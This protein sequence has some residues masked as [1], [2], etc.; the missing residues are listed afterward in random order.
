[1]YHEQAFWGPMIIIV[2]GK[3]DS[4]GTARLQTETDGGRMPSTIPLDCVKAKRFRTKSAW[5]PTEFAYVLAPLV[6][7]ILY[8]DSSLS[9]IDLHPGT[10]LISMLVLRALL[11]SA[12]RD[13]AGVT[14]ATRSP[15]W[16]C[17]SQ[18]TVADAAWRTSS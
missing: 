15:A 7:F 13:L 11:L 6:A 3:R 17:L 16:V 2:C 12:G 18:P 5:N 10:E 4:E 9:Y 1:M 14:V 8:C